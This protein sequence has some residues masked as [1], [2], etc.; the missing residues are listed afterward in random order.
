MA[1]PLAEIARPLTV[2][3][4]LFS[5]CEDPILNIG[6]FAEKA[7]FRQAL[8]FDDEEQLAKIPC[9]NDVELAKVFHHTVS[10]ATAASFKMCS[11]LNSTWQCS[12]RSTRAA[13]LEGL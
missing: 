11:S 10:C 4:Q 13:A 12:R 6:D 3:D 5:K 2:V 9:L 7:H 1:M 8:K